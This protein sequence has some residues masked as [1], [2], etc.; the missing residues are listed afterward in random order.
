MQPSWEHCIQTFLHSHITS[1]LTVDLK[2]TL[3][4]YSPHGLLVFSPL[5]RTSS[6]RWRQPAFSNKYARQR[7]AAASLNNL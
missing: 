2:C 4:R 1:R 5:A 6:T 3:I 7:W